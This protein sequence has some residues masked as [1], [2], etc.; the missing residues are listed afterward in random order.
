M[1]A[2][3]LLTSLPP[4]R[5]GMDGGPRPLARAGPPRAGLPSEVPLLS[6][7]AGLTAGWHSGGSSVSLRGLSRRWLS[8][9][10]FTCDFRRQRGTV[11]EVPRF[12][13]RGTCGRGRR[14]EESLPEDLLPRPSH[15]LHLCLQ[16]WVVTGDRL[17][18]AQVRESC[19]PPPW[20]GVHLVP[21]WPCCPPALAPWPAAL[22]SWWPRPLTA[23]SPGAL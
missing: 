8:P 7:T 20:S 11:T 19:P 14:W 18:P 15:V 6:H 12:Q 17:M 10:P 4:S 9:R 22:L 13:G 5:A 1:A 21:S 23:P 2:G 16:P 3:A